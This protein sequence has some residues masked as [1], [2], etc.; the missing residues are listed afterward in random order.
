[1]RQPGGELALKDVSRL[2]I[3]G[4]LS[5]QACDDKVCFTPQSTP[6]SWTVRLRQLDLERARP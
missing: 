2:N 5:Y 3:A 1:M 6:L 4:M